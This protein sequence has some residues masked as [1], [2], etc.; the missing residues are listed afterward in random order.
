MRNKKSMALLVAAVMVFSFA[1]VPPAH[2]FVGI[3]ALGAIIAATFASA[4]LVKQAAVKQAKEPVPEH[5]ASIHKTL[6][7]IR[8]SNKP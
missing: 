2:A 6:S 7:K 4:V 1:A 5:S 8:A 3:A